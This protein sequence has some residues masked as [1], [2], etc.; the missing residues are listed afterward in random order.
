[1]GMEIVRQESLTDH[2]NHCRLWLYEDIYNI[3]RKKKYGESKKQHDIYFMLHKLR[4]E[5]KDSFGLSRH[6]PIKL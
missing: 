3:L 1:M 5:I 4:L 6:M 2:G